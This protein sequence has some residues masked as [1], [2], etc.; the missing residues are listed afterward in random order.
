VKE[1]CDYR[2][3]TKFEKDL[4]R[5][6]DYKFEQAKI[7]HSE[8]TVRLNELKNKAQTERDNQLANVD[9]EI[10]KAAELAKSAES[11]INGL[12]ETQNKKIK[13]KEKERDRLQELFN[14]STIL[15]ASPFRRT[16][17]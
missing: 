11:E 14:L 8:T 17:R 9:L 3:F 12:E 6:N 16:L 2:T 7:K 4:I 1:H 10:D 5:E 13:E 15:K